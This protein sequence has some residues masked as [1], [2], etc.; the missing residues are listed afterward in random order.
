MFND[1]DNPYRS[2]VDSS[3]GHYDWSLAKQAFLAC[4]LIAILYLIPTTLV[5][6]QSFRVSFQSHNKTTTEQIWRFATSW[7]SQ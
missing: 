1:T 4:S 2:P 7:K 3:T 6:W 5:A